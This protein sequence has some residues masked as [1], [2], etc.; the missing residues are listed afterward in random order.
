LILHSI[1]YV[2]SKNESSN[3]SQSIR[4][5]KEALAAL[6]AAEANN[7]AS[8]MDVSVRPMKPTTEK[9]VLVEAAGD[10]KPKRRVE[11]YILN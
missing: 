8:L 3:N 11:R 5:A 2:A 9:T 4:G 7:P 10:D 1:R 6:Q